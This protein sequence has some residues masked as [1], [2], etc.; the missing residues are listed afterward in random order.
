MNT[1]IKEKILKGMAASPGIAIGTPFH[2]VHETLN[3]SRESVVDHEIESEIVKYRASLE[4]VRQQ[5]AEDRKNAM[6]RGGSDAAK[7]FD[8][9]LM[10]V[11]DQVLTDEVIY[12]ISAHNV[13]SSYAVSKVMKDYQAAFEKI[14]NQYFSQRAFDIED[15]CRRIVKDL[16]SDEKQKGRSGVIKGRQIVISDNIFPSDTLNFNKDHLLGIIT[17]FGGITS[18]AAILSRALEVPAIV[19]VKSVSK[20]IKNATLII[21]DGYAG[22]VILNPKPSTFEKY[23]KRQHEDEK[24]LR[25]DLKYSSLPSVTEDGQNISIMSNIQS[26]SEADNAIRWN[27]DGVGLFRTEFLFK[28]SNTILSEDEQFKVYDEV[29]EKL[30]PRHVVIRILDIGGDKLDDK[31]AVKEDNP[32]LGQRGMRLLF[33]HTR[34]L[35]SHLR[36]IVRASSRK[37]VSIIIPFV[38]NLTEIKKTLNLIKKIRKELNDEGHIIDNEIKTGVMIEIP[39]AALTADSIAKYVDFFS[40]GTND[41]TQYVLAADRGN[42]RVSN[43]YDSFHPAVIRLI[44]MSVKAAKKKKIGIG[45]CGQMG[46]YPMAIPLLLGLGLRELS[47]T[48]F[49]VPSVKKIIRRLNT[50]ECREIAKKCLKSPTS[51]SVSVILSDYFEKKIGNNPLQ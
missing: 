1:K 34:I 35:R 27:S 15:V 38:A 20:W 11:N 21:L 5:L 43:I 28:S 36:A 3:I 6:K 50:A 18:H 33:T 12:F 16:I 2:Y 39:S 24:Q 40:I 26:S 49:L 23:K 22:K 48:P 41:L 8:S 17:E 7:I 44:D 13:K 32:F 25:D 4:S 30:Y 19:G 14:K 10:I 47:V 46:G 51:R 45:I 9:H 31:I 42:E 29:A 37:N